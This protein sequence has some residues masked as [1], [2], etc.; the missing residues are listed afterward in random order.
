MKRISYISADGEQYQLQESGDMLVVRTKKAVPLTAG[1]LSAAARKLVS[2]FSVVE[3]IERADV[4]ILQIKKTVKD[5]AALK[6]QAR[7]ILKKEKQLRF[8]GRVFVDK[9]SRRWVIYTNNIFIKFSEK[10]NAKRCLAVLKKYQ[11]K[12]KTKIKFSANAWFVE[13]DENAPQDVFKIC[14]QLFR[15]REVVYCEPELI[16]KTGKKNFVPKI[17]FRQWHLKT[18]VIGKRKIEAS[19]SVEAAH[20]LTKGKG[21]TIAIIDD[22]VDVNHIEFNQPGKCVWGKDISFNTSDPMPKNAD[23]NHGTCCAGVACAS[24][25][26][27]A[28]GV[29]PDARLMPIRCVSYL[30]SKDEAFAIVHAVDKGADVISC[31]WGPEDGDWWSTRSKLHGRRHSISALTDDAIKYAVKKGRKGKGCIILFAAGNGNETC[32]PDKYISHPD[33]IAVSACNDRGKKSIYSDYGKCVWVCFPSN[34]FV[35]KNF[36]HPRPLTTGIWTTDRSGKKGHKKKN[37]ANY[38]G[39]FGGTSSACPGVAGVCALILAVNP[40][41]TYNEVKEILR[42]TADKI[43]LNNGNYDE[44][45]HSEWYGYGRV[46]AAKATELSVTL[47]RKKGS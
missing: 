26:N 20:Q 34:D 1:I 35:A 8:A 21:T 42:L 12:I 44:D 33:V 30:G 36:K 13:P 18:T 3:F 16:R 27:K 6:T 15:R 37:F 2:K 10:L 23:D 40:S 31:S 28:C 4:Y 24:G 22:G 39:T 38:T 41:L 5:A 32:D 46:N 43:D 19:A 14:R 17:H 25:K 7:E 29:A 11:L 45:G 47:R 9:D